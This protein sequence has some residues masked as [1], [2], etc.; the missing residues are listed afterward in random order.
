MSSTTWWSI[1]I[2]QKVEELWPAQDLTN[3]GDNSRT[4]S[5]LLFL[6]CDPPTNVLYNLIKYHDNISK[7][8]W[9]MACTR[10]H[11]Y[12]RYLQNAVSQSCHSCT[13]HPCSMSSTYWW[14]I[15][16]I[17]Y[18][19]LELSAAQDSTTMGDNSQRESARVVVLVCDTPIQCPLQLDQ[20][21]WKYLKELLLWPAQDF[22][23][24]G[25]NS[26]TQ[27]VR[28]V[29]LIRHTPTQCPLPNGEKSWKYL[30]GF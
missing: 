5:E 25:Y 1:K 19:V 17:T 15:M 20:V 10:F 28:V 4:E 14:S 9:V 21:S 11:I 24:M 6:L 3:M 30:K 29:F 26:R 12:G 8:Y 7:G 2:S 22:I 13:W 27:S 16:K 23:T 18:K